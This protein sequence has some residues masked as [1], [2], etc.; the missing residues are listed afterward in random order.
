[1]HINEFNRRK[2]KAIKDDLASINNRVRHA[3][4]QGVE[5]GKELA[6]EENRGEQ[7]ACELCTLM[8]KGDTF[9]QMT[10]WDGRLGFDYIY[11]NFC[12]CNAQVR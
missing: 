6:E 12:P 11:V 2:E 8:H 10:S 7:E 9:Y 1:M 3:F 5:L 4:N